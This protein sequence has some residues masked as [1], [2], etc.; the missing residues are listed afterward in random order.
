MT[1]NAQRE[2]ATIYQFPVG[3]RAGLAPRSG[4][5]RTLGPE[6]LPTIVYGGSWYHDEAIRE[7]AET[8]LKN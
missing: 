1:T 3:G 2:S 5:N 4:L 6:I 8:A 7:A